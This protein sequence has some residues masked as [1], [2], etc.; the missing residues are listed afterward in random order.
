MALELTTTERKLAQKLLFTFHFVPDVTAN[1][2][3]KP[4]SNKPIHH[5]LDYADFSTSKSMEPIGVF[6]TS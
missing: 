2:T 1:F 4:A 3:N 6:E 5:L